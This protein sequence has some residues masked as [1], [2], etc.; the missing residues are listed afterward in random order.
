MFSFAWL[1]QSSLTAQGP[2]VV[3]DTRSLFYIIRLFS[4]SLVGPSHWSEISPICSD[5]GESPV[6]INEERTKYDSSLAAF[7]FIGYDTV[8]SGAKYILEN[9]RHAGNQWLK[10]SRIIGWI[11]NFV[12]IFNQVFHDTHFWQICQ[13][14][15]C[16]ILKWVSTPCCC[17]TIWQCIHSHTSTGNIKKP[18]YI[19][20][21]L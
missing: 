11:L 13:I 9:N 14:S 2:V 15:I 21:K 12:L 20:S 3:G 7:I 18:L 17:L 5:V 4:V 1:I 8:P 10:C 16:Q 6:D 19:N